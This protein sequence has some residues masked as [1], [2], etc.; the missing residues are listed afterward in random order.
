VGC[1]LSQGC[2]LRGLALG[3]YLAAP[4]GLRKAKVSTLPNQSCVRYVCLHLVLAMFLPEACPK[5]VGVEV[6]RL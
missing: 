6:T 5:S 1:D 2:G 3:Y 4:P